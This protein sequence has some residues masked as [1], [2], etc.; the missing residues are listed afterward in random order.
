MAE[1]FYPQWSR[2]ISSDKALAQRRDV[3]SIMKLQGKE[4]YGKSK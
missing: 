4:V 3:F 1:E 2:F